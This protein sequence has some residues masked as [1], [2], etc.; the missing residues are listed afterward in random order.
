MLSLNLYT[1]TVLLLPLIYLDYLFLN[2]VIKSSLTVS[3]L[4]KQ[5]VTIVA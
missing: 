1:I 5:K 4:P 3:T 2:G